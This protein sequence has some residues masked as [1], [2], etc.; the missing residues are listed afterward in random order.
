M[1][2]KHRNART[3]RPSVVSLLVADA[4][5]QIRYKGNKSTPKRN[6]KIG[7]AQIAGAAL[8]YEADV[9][10]NFDPDLLDNLFRAIVSIG[11]LPHILYLEVTTQSGIG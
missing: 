8:A 3:N 7:D 10:H 11:W 9:L 4:A 1:T 2:S 5:L 6:V